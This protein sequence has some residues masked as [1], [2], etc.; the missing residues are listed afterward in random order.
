M[1]KLFIIVHVL[2][3]K[4]F[5]NFLILEEELKASYEWKSLCEVITRL[6]EIEDFKKESFL[7][8]N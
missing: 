6:F 2:R 4:E 7:G 5:L 8:A 1:H 3:V